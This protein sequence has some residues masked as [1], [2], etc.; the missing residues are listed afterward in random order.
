MG[1]DDGLLV[2]WRAVQ[3]CSA[4]RDW[5]RARLI[6]RRSLPPFTTT[7]RPT[8]IVMLPQACDRAGAVF[9]SCPLMIMLMA[10]ICLE[11]DGIGLLI[12]LPAVLASVA[13]TGA[14][15]GEPSR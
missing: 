15:S 5:P 10:R 2:A 13:I 8:G 4:R 9:P 12:A 11:E 7:K 3:W 1:E 6:R 14:A